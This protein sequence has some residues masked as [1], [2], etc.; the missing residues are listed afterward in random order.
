MF[1]FFLNFFIVENK[2]IQLQSPDK[3]AKIYLTVKCQ[4]IGEVN[5]SQM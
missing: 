1:I 3:N 2:M 4:K 5:D